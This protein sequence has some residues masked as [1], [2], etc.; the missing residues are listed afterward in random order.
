MTKNFTKKAEYMFWFF[1]SKIAINLS[2]GLY[3]DVQA[4]GEAFTLKIEHPAVKN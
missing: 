3:K 4:T 2:L 1:S